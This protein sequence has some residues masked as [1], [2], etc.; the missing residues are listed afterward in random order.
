MTQPYVYFNIILLL[1]TNNNNNNNNN[2]SDGV[3]I[4]LY[5]INELLRPKFRSGACKNLRNSLYWDATWRQL[6][7][8]C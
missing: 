6:V 4:L 2:F 7:A 8:G 5:F 3:H 1:L